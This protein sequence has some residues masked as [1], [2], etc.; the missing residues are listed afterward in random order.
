MNS[1]RNPLLEE[2]TWIR[3][4]CLFPKFRR[5]FPLLSILILISFAVFNYNYN[6]YTPNLRIY[7][8]ET[9]VMEPHSVDLEARFASRREHLNKKCMEI[10]L[11]DG[12]LVPNAREFVIN[13]EYQLVWCNVFK[14]ASTSWIY[15][16]N[17]LIGYSREELMKTDHP[18]LYMLRQKYP[19]PSIHK[20]LQALNS[21][22]SFIIVRHPLERLVSAYRDKFLNSRGNKFYV[23]MGL[24]II[25]TS[26]SKD[27]AKIS[28]MNS[29]SIL[30]TFKEFINY[31]ICQWKAGRQLDEHWRP[32]IESCTPCL[33]DFDIIIK[34]ETM[35]EDQEYLIKL[36]K[37]EGIIEPTWLNQ[38]KSSQTEDV[39]KDYYSQL[40]RNQIQE[41][42]VL[43]K[44]D[45]EIFGYYMDEYLS[46]GQNF[47][48]PL[49]CNNK[50]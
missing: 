30:P 4:R 36:A 23:N 14:A 32:I 22:L 45:L 43:Y 42:A 33:I 37:L 44:Y 46:I 24:K 39:I 50:S 18:P 12:N 8:R 20:L 16:F 25:N 10:N 48:T 47:D 41:L 26:R 3:N 27:K 35:Q 28:E 21:S 17:L 34:F 31:V 6:I 1:E 29:N 19:R 13:H 2:K 5:F 49:H 15:N 40:S 7:F 9:E 38:A 11:N